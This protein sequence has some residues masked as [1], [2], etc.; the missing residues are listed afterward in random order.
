MD[1]TIFH[2]S[3]NALGVKKAGLPGFFRSHGHRDASVSGKTD[4]KTDDRPKGGGRRP[5]WCGGADRA[6]QGEI[7]RNIGGDGG[8]KI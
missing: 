4:L 8:V 1:F 7:W 3:P 5:R 2:P 6:F